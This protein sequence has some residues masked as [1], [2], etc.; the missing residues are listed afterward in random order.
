LENRKRVEKKEKNPYVSEKKKSLVRVLAARKLGESPPFVV[1]K[2]CKRGEKR[3]AP[4]RR[5]FPK[6]SSRWLIVNRGKEKSARKGQ[7][8][9]G[10][11]R[12]WEDCL[13]KQESERHNNNSE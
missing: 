9:V 13:L 5:K 2:G 7:G 10:E 12:E 8:N 6:A 3:G 1:I 11:I 4:Q